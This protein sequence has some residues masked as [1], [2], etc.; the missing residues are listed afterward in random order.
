MTEAFSK[1]L[2]LIVAFWAAIR[3]WEIL[4]AE[5]IGFVRRFGKP[6]RALKIGWNWRWPLIEGAESVNGQEGV[7]VLDPQ[8][9][10]T[11]DGI[12]VVV[13]VSVT[14]RVVDAL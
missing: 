7:Y 5:E 2:D 4:P 1:I 9:L 14:F 11:S 12:E 10:R 3:C 8:S 13:R 6:A